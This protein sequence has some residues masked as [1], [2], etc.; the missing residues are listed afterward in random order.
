[1][2]AFDRGGDIDP[3]DEHDSGEND[4][5]DTPSSIVDRPQRFAAVERAGMA[6][7]HN[8]ADAH[9]KNDGNGQLRQ[10]P[11]QASDAP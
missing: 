6:E 1:M 11:L 5:D 2:E 8:D 3:D 10:P 9:E 4:Q 7:R